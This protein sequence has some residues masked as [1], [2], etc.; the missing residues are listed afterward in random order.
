[1]SKFQLRAIEINSTLYQFK[2]VYPYSTTEMAKMH[3][4]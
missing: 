1:M 2:I 4:S 3:L